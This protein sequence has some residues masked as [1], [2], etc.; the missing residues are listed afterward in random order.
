MLC[1]HI[2]TLPSLS[3]KW[4]AQEISID[5]YFTK[6]LNTSLMHWQGSTDL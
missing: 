2:E 3:S 6:V 5:G 1:G 4:K